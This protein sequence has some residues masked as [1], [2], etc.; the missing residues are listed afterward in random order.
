MIVLDS[1]F[2]ISYYNQGDQNHAAARRV[3]EDLM[4][5]KWG[6][7]LLLEYVF[8]E[9]ATVLRIRVGLDHA[10][11]VGDVLLHARGM[12]FV[13]C[14]QHFSD[15]VETFRNSPAGVSFVDAAIIT[16]ARARNTRRVVTFNRAFRRLRDIEV[17]P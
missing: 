16:I 6:L 5:G 10:T 17:V 11:R 1:S 12:E 13:P 4:A 15:A 9:V 2:L 8:L 7:A 14:S 3:M